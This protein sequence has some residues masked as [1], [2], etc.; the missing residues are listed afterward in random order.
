M[1]SRYDALPEKWIK[2]SV[3]G[4]TWAA[5]EIVLGSFLHNLKV[6][7]TGN[8]LTALGLII[9]ITAGHIW[10]EKGLFWRA[11]LICAFMKT[12]SPS[13]FIFGPMVAILSESLLLEISV[14]LLGRS[15]AGY[16]AGAMLAM[17]WNLFQK[18]IN[19]LVIY[20]SG[21]VDLYNGLVDWVAGLLRIRGG[22]G[23][24]PILLLL[25]LYG[26]FG[27]AAALAGRV[28]GRRI[29]RR[30]FLPEPAGTLPAGVPAARTV[31][32]GFPY[33]LVWLFADLAFLA[34]GLLLLAFAHPACWMVFVAAVITLW[35]FRYNRALRRLRKPGFWITLVL[36]TMATALLFTGARP[37][38]LSLQEGILTGLQMNFRAALL[39][40]GFSVLGTELYNPAV[41]RFFMG[42]RFRQL[43]VALE[44]SFESL[45]YLVAHVPGFRSILRNP[46]AVFTH[47]LAR[48]EIRLA[49]V[50]E[51]IRRT[52]Q[53][54]LLR[55]AV[56][57][58]K[59]GCLQQLVRR[60]QAE[61]R[62]V[63]GIL[64]ERVMEGRETAGY[65]VVVIATGQRSPFLRRGNGEAGSIGRFAICREGLELGVKALSPEAN[66][67]ME[68]VIVDE[69][70]RLE[71]RGEGWAGSI[72]A[73]LEK[74]QPPLLLSVNGKL[75]A[76]IARHWDFEPLY[77]ASA[78]QG[79]C[80]L[81][82]DRILRH[83]EVPG[84]PAAA[85]D[86]VPPPPDPLAGKRRLI[87]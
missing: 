64:S 82:I 73:L 71:L 9:L 8:L 87:P 61:N 63:G 21:M 30:D 43:P 55:G 70:G 12:L 11:G 17:A 48:T 62:K 40:T 76:E 10:S 22:N 4:T 57:T 66:R 45:P 5:F 36:I 50:K 14:R 56:E 33:S 83:L 54:F 32:A 23:W 35:S 67:D 18:I 52:P 44:L 26:L 7:F 25:A 42:S 29:A 28:I 80:P 53:V 34:G 24:F 79:D 38:S 60:L 51:R 75:A 84:M 41:R 19:L 1:K 39:I 2:A 49:E 65:D 16:A 27:L 20:G 31:S 3:I 85:L 81:L 58:G 77:E 13:A 6:P 78:E 74:G 15:L 59:T 46:V 37:G 68:L 86:E 72:T 69:T 47:F